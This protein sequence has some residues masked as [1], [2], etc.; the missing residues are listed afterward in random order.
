MRGWM[1]WIDAAG[2]EGDVVVLGVF[3]AIAWG[4]AQIE[5]GR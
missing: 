4:L 5:R 2:W 1:E 3:G